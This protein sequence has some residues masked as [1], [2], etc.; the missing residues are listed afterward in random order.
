VLALLAHLA[1]GGAADDRLDG[2]RRG[3]R[4]GVYPPG[5][6]KRPNPL[7]AQPTSSRMG[8]ESRRRATRS[9]A[10]QGLEPYLPVP[11]A[12]LGSPNRTDF[13]EQLDRDAEVIGQREGFR[14]RRDPPTMK[15][16]ADVWLQHSFDVLLPRRFDVQEVPEI[17][18]RGF[19]H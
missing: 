4:G 15:D 13:K 7:S 2:A 6:P 17:F 18:G 11:S 5:T 16:C 8:R 19:L 3:F 14:L 10:T 9:T 12:R 1:S